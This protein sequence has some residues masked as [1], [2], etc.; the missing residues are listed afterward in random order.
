VNS[1][2]IRVLAILSWAVLAS[3]LVAAKIDIR[4]DYDKMFDFKSI[5]TFAWHPEGAGEYKLLQSSGEDPAT[6]R[7]L[8]EPTIV[9]A[10][11]QN[12]VSRGLTKATAMPD[13]NVSY[14]VLIG[15][16]IESQT[17]GQFLRPVPEWGIAPFAPGTSAL[18]IYEQGSLILNIA[19]AAQDKMVW[20]GSAKTEIDRQNSDKERNNRIR[21]AVRDMI[22][23]LPN[24]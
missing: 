19:S 11:E 12:L 6:L 23:K 2:A 1:K 20:R 14:Y 21:D 9:S 18:E 16:N 15:P 5:R 24:K 13:V 10:V 8:L 3:T 7:K 4:A 22:K 17:H